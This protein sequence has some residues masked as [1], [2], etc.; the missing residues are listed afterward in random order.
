MAFNPGDVVLVPFPFRDQLGE[1]T[2]PAAIVSDT[3]FNQHGDLVVAAI[4]SISPRTAFDYTIVDWKA[5]GLLVPSTIRM[6]LATTSQ[7]RIVHVLGKL[8]ASDWDEVKKRV[9]RVFS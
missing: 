4:T 2:R 9:L 5:A 8:S 7:G 1:K 3:T 6:L